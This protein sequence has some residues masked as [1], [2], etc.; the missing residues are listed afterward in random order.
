M[1][2]G[3]WGRGSGA[4]GSCGKLG[5]SPSRSVGGR[6]SGYAVRGFA[7]RTLD[8][9]SFQFANTSSRSSFNCFRASAVHEHMASGQ[10]ASDPSGACGFAC[11]HMVAH[12]WL[13]VPGLMLTHEVLPPP[14][15]RGSSAHSAFFIVPSA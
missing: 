12:H 13:V 7:P 9:A 8:S 3:A 2:G 14:S 5:S 1:D 15:L 10:D 4:R 11:E 6:P